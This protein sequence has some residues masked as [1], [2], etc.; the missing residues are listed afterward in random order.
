M[1]LYL[2]FVRDYEANYPQTLKYIIAINV[3]SS[4]ESILELA[5]PLMSPEY[6]NALKLFGDNK[7]E[8]SNWLL[9]IIS[10][11]QLS[12]QFGGIR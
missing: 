2:N 11:D 4:F 8:W 3:P 12:P 5:I 10:P 1:P 9:T 7:A 6:R